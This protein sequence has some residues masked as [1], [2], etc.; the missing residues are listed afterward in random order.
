MNEAVKI[1][2]ID[3]VYEV[4]TGYVG[5][6]CGCNGK[7]SVASKYKKYANKQRGYALNNISDRSVKIIYNK[8]VKA[9]N[10]NEKV[11]VSSKHNYAYVE[12]GERCLAAYFVE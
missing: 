1:P 11:E 8:I 2:S 3:K 12:K 9:I 5:C 4:Y 6:M 7:Y 10:N